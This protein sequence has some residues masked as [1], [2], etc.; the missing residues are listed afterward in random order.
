[1]NTPFLLHS[2]LVW[3]DALVQHEQSLI[4]HALHG[5][6][7]HQSCDERS[8]II[9]KYLAEAD[10]LLAW[11]TYARK[12]LQNE[13][14]SL[15][16]QHVEP[17]DGEVLRRSR[18]AWA[19]SLSDDLEDDSGDPVMRLLVEFCAYLMAWGVTGSAINLMRPSEHPFFDELSKRLI[20]L[21]K[22]EDMTRPRKRETIASSSALKPRPPRSRA[23]S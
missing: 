12:C 13:F 20:P 22:D 7:L 2:R 10:R 8:K 19:Q 5:E 6:L 1:M 17:Y 4:K 15:P 23:N 21:K 18:A 16:R 14:S 11:E 3:L 9:A